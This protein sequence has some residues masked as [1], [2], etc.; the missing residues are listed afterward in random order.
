MTSK[1]ELKFQKDLSFLRSW[2]LG[3]EFYTALKAME[4]AYSYHSGYRKDQVTPE[5]HHQVQIALNA[6]TLCYTLLRPE[7]TFTV[8]FLHDVPEDFDVEFEILANKFGDFVT[9]ATR[10]VTKKYKGAQKP[11]ESYFE[12]MT[13]CPVASLVKGLDRCHNVWTMAGVFSQE[14]IKSYANEIDDYFLPMLK[15]ARKAFP[16][17]EMAYHN[18]AHQLRTM[19]DIYRWAV[20]GFEE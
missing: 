6:R 5:F 8:I 4:F 13:H 3:K 2:L 7:D 14:K 16:E 17:Q 10:K 9:S 18:V 12:E 11:Y 15:E 19:R 20:K 1:A